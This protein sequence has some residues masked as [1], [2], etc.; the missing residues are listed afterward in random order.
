[1][2]TSLLTLEH[3]DR[4]FSALPATPVTGL[5]LLPLPEST[6]SAAFSSRFRTIMS[7]A[8][9][10][11][12]FFSLLF[13]DYPAAGRSGR[14]LRN[15]RLPAVPSDGRHPAELLNNVQNHPPTSRDC[16]KA[17]M[18]SSLFTRRIRLTGRLRELFPKFPGQLV[19]V[20]ISISS[21]LIASAPIAA[22]KFLSVDFSCLIV[23]GFSIIQA[24]F[25][26]VSPDPL[27]Y[28]K[29]SRALSPILLG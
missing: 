18:T 2:E 9:S 27:R 12:S 1:M 3:L 14:K 28:R 16:L 7:G 10:S 8:P 15:V 13:P 5:P 19:Y 11:N 17:S 4:D 26:R 22:L 24:V 6:D 25:K 21:C 23:L 20:S 29:Q